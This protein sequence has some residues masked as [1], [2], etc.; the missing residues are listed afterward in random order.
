M[1][2]ISHQARAATDTMF[3]QPSLIIRT[4]GG[5]LRL[6]VVEG[7]L[8]IS[9][10]AQRRQEGSKPSAPQGHWYMSLLENLK[11][12]SASTDAPH[13]LAIGVPQRPGAYDLLIRVTHPWWT[14]ERLH[15]VEAHLRS[16]SEI[17][18]ITVGP[19]LIRL[20]ISDDALNE[21]LR[22]PRPA[23]DASGR[24]L[25][26]DYCDPNATKAL[27][28]GHLRNLSIGNALA[29]LFE[30][31]GASVTRQSVVCDIG[32]S[33]AEALSGFTGLIPPAPNTAV[34]GDHFVGECY[35]V[36][37]RSHHSQTEGAVGPADQPMV[38]EF[39]RTRDYLD[40]LYDLWRARDPLV[41]AAWLKMRALVMQG[42]TETFVRLGIRLD[43]IVYESNWN[44]SV[45][46][47]AATGL[48]TGLF[49]KNDDEAVVFDTG[50]SEQPELVMVRPDGF[51]TVHL[52]T[53]AVWVGIDGRLDNEELIQVI[54]SEWTVQS[55]C[56]ETML[57]ALLGDTRR[58]TPTINVFHGMVDVDGS[59]VT[60][61]EGGALLI[62]DLLDALTLEVE[63]WDSGP[64]AEDGGHLASTLALGLFISQP[65]APT[66]DIRV[67]DF[68]D[69]SRNLLLRICQALHVARCVAGQTR[70]PPDVGDQL[71]RYLA[72]RGAVANAT[73]SVA[74][75]RL[76]PF[77]LTRF[78]AHI[79]R[80]YLEDDRSPEVS[81]VAV[82]LLERGLEELGFGLLRRL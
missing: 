1:I 54:G 16:L 19:R 18:E 64:F 23:A 34:K 14:Q 57:S 4:L 36:G 29:S 15:N 71:V 9:L 2:K 74:R 30:A 11:A 66:L 43:R 79:A 26:I 27:H 53:L 17:Q 6:L 12:A 72:I 28:I 46:R 3:H 56:L 67:E 70:D 50:L 39:K 59:H 20:R 65:S 81:G 33:V 31:A 25:T 58:S 13:P 75:A 61:S 62:D 55:R 32:R 35:A 8:P 22:V 40:D 69:P 45:E 48:H 73:A 37:V 47:V 38:R 77:L 41:W 63:Q 42:H 10:I 51:P 49:R 5:I 44:A 82:D 21:C 76:E 60:S 68:L 52:R 24:R 78:Y 7:R 80:W